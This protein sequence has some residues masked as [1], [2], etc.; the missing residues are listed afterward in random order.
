MLPGK[1]A[2]VVA[3]AL[4]L[5]AVV[6]L[7]TGGSLAAGDDR[8]SASSERGRTEQPRGPAA[9]AAESLA[10]LGYVDGIVDESIEARGCRSTS[11]A[12]RST[13]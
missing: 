6:W 9:V 7:G 8:A 13:A 2:V 5:L 4:A 1:L 10:S 11:A 12:R 3:G